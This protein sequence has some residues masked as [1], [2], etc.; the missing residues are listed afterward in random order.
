MSYEEYQDLEGTGYSTK[1]PVPPEQEFFH[2]VYISGKNRKNH[3]NIVEKSGMLQVRGVEYNLESVNM[4]ITHVKTILSREITVNNKTSLSCFSYQSGEWPWKGTSKDETGNIR[5]CGKTSAERAADPWCKDCR[6]QI[7]ISGMYCDDKEK[8]LRTADKNPIF[9]FFRGKGIKYSVVSDMLSEY[10][11]IENTS[12]I[13]EPVTEESKKFERNIV[14]NKRFV[15][16]ITAG[17]TDTKYGMHNNFVFTRGGELPKDAVLNVLKMSKKTLDK[18]NEKFDWS[19]G[20]QVAS[21]YTDGTKKPDFTPDQKFEDPTS[22]TQKKEET[23]SIKTESKPTIEAFSF[24]DV[25]F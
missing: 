2:S 24:E 21:N 3:I 18:F 11:K 1:A 12:P 17:T 5:T 6:S 10:A 4:I 16:K 25:D 14:N 8:P 15:T 20:K 19:R 7:I 9:I 23:P 22:Q 13:F